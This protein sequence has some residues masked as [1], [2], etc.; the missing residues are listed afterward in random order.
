MSGRSIETADGRENA[1]LKPEN[2]IQRE[3]K[4]Q[5]RL[6]NIISTVRHLLY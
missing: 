5:T 1:E 2:I 3:V 4:E 6:V